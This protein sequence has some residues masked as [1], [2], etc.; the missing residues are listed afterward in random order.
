MA[1]GCSAE[2]GAP[3]DES[4]SVG[5]TSEA[6]T[7]TGNLAAGF[8]L[9]AA[10]KRILPGSC[11]VRDF[12]NKDWILMFGG[13]DTTP[14]PLSDIL[15]LDVA[16]GGG[17]SAAIETGKTTA[18]TLPVALGEIQAVQD[19][20]DVHSCWMVGGTT[21]V[22]GNAYNTAS[23]VRKISIDN[24][25]KFSLTTPAGASLPRV[26]HRVRA[27]GHSVISFGGINNA[28]TPQTGIHYLD[29]T[30]GA[31][32]WASAGTMA[33][34]RLD[35]G[36]TQDGSKFV[37]G[38][39]DLGGSLDSRVAAL[40][41]TDGTCTAFSLGES[42]NGFVTS[43][44]GG[45]VMRHPTTAN[46]YIVGA[47]EIAGGT[48]ASTGTQEVDVNWAN[49]PPTLSLVGAGTALSAAVKLPILASVTKDYAIGGFNAT[50]ASFTTNAVQETYWNTQNLPAGAGRVDGNA[51]VLGGNIYVFAGQDTTNGYLAP[52]VKIVP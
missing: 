19:P 9:S 32:A 42:A 51:E 15:K 8:D 3:G 49:T 29:V 35:F 7:S 11:V 52:V 13:F 48:L 6:L 31:P 23:T 45:I 47:G 4:A 14:S 30:A 24:T 10:Q 50:P 39:A 37:I 28:G 20:T 16:T 40:K 1:V 44:A 2:T 41:D 34:G 17:W 5:S 26:Q 33:V 25:G 12:A 36:L 46:R 22:G 43:R 21:T 18:L 27:C 38:T